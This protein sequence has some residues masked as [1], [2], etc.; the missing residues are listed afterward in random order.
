MASTDLPAVM[1]EMAEL[2]TKLWKS[3][4]RRVPFSQYMVSIPFADRSIHQCLDH[5]LVKPPL[6]IFSLFD[7][8]EILRNRMS[9][10]A[11]AIALESSTVLRPH[12]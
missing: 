5:I 7:A 6:P 8:R 2:T 3:L 12:V 9:A 11:I 10:R 4:D 1:A